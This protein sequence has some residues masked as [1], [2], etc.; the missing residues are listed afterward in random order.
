[1]SNIRNFSLKRIIRDLKEINENP[2]EGIG[3]ISLNDDPM[4]YIINIQLMEGIYKNYCLQL[5]LIFYNNYPIRPPKI[6][7]YPGQIFDQKY[8]HHIFK[9]TQKDENGNNFQI[10]FRFIG[11]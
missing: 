7:I 2:I 10:L 3:I 4:K 8:H 1:M 6:L 9:D 5:L 11:K